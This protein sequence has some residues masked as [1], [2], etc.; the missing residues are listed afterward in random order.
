MANRTARP[1]SGEIGSTPASLIR[2]APPL[3][4]LTYSLFFS[5]TL[6][7]SFD[8]NRPP[9][10][11][12]RPPNVCLVGRDPHSN[13]HPTPGAPSLAAD[14]AGQG[15]FGGNLETVQRDADRAASFQVDS[16]SNKDAISTPSSPASRGTP[17]PGVRQT[18]GSVLAS[19]GPT[20]S[21]QNSTVSPSTSP[22]VTSPLQDRDKE[23][24]RLLYPSRVLLTSKYLFLSLPPLPLP[25]PHPRP[26]VQP[27]PTST[28]SSPTRSNGAPQTPSCAG[29]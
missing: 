20:V 25:H 21:P 23:R 7:P 26:R 22:A 24:E 28:A 19:D 6:P 17:I 12:T 27:T 9:N 13:P 1:T 4:I 10:C 3:S 14:T 18:A 5:L 15:E 2:R 16:L 29:P 8:S 11:P